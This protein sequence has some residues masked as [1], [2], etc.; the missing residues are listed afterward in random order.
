MRHLTHDE[1]IPLV[2]TREDLLA[3]GLSARQIDETGAKAT[4]RRVHRN[5]YVGTEAWSELW[6]E[7]RHRLEV[8]AAA[9]EMRGGPGVVSHISAAAWWGLPLFRRR[10]SEVELTVHGPLR[11][12]TRSGIRRHLDRLDRSDVQV[13]EDLRCTSLER[14]VFDVA[15][16]EPPEVA[17]VCLDAALRSVSVKGREWDAAAHGEW[18]GRMFERC[19][20]AAGRRGV[21]RARWMIDLADGRAESPGESVSR[22]QLV[23]LG[24]ARPHLQVSVPGPGSRTYWVDFGLEDVHA[25]GE[26]DGEGKYMDIAVRGNRSLDEVIYAEKLREDWIRGRSQRRFARW[27]DEHIG[28]PELLRRRLAGFGIRPPL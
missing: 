15:R 18:K 9:M 17:L 7:S 1:L 20:A 26:F 12:A 27:G 28:T 23:R 24:F 2:R 25:F 3:E 8:Y 14:T 5:R 10:P 6:P 11:A 16:I 19:R 21:R 4:V 13:H 22:L